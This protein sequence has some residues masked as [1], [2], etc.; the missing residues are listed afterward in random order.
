MAE[1][2]RN[3]PA[4]YIIGVPGSEVSSQSHGQREF[5]QNRAGL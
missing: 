1:M 2:P 4:L 3:N 5:L